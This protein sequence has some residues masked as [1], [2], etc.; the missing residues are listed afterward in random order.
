[1]MR[2][3]LNPLV[4]VAI[5]L[6]ACTD[7]ERIT[8]PADGLAV[9]YG[10]APPGGTSAY[11]AVDLGVL[12]GDQE[13]YAWAASDAG[14]VLVQS[15]KYPSTGGIVG[16]WFVRSGSAISQ[17]NN[18]ALSGLSN[19]TTA[20][21]LSAR[22]RWTFNPSS[23][24]TSPLTLDS[25]YG[26]SASARAVNELGM[27]T[28]SLSYP[29]EGGSASDAVIWNADGTG[30]AIANP[31]PDSIRAGLGR[32]INNA[33]DIVISYTG[34][35]NPGVG[36]ARPDRGYVRTADGVLIELL[37]LPNHRSTYA[38]GV[39]ERN[40]GTVYVAGTSDDDNGSYNAVRWTIDVASHAVVGSSV[41][42]GPSYSEAIADNG[43]FVGVLAGSSQSGF[44]WP[45][46]GSVQSLK[47]PKSGTN[48]RVW[49]ISGNGRYIAGDAKFGSYRHAVLWTVQ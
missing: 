6:T 41:A 28:G 22:T 23:G 1:M 40:G 13:S 20:F 30:I 29:V 24:F 15:I 25:L 33:G 44:V 32:D 31:K 42:P 17:F 10:K 38:Y 47:T 39:S 18:G 34:A 9:S 37:P 19:G 3:S 49:G 26:Y 35:L 36:M 16:H 27:S 11:T 48:G 4:L 45:V 46:G 43:T 2:S 7:S 5:A 21:T 14:Y 8:S 12:A